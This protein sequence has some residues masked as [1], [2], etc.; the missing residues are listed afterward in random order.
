MD[1]RPIGI[2][3][4]GLGGLTAAGE[5]ARLLPSEHIIYFGDTGR[6]PYGSRSKETIL[7]YAN[8]DVAFLKSFDLKAIVIACGTVSTVAIEQLKMQN[9]LPIVGVVEPAAMMA[10]KV[11]QNGKVGLIG[12]SASV[13]SG[14]YEKVIASVSLDINVTAQACPLLVPLIEAGRVHEG[15][16][17]TETVLSE[18]LEPMKKAQ[19][20]TLVLG[21]THYPLLK[22]MIAKQMGDHVTL[23]DTGEEC[24][25]HVAIL[26]KEQDLL[27]SHTQTEGKRQYFVSDA[28]EG[29]VRTASF[30][31]GEQ[32]EDAVERVDIDTYQF[33]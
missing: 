24:A 4:S 10:A 16:C 29:F 30:F 5:L 25:K 26:L 20:D 11:T 8:Q 33:D 21:C 28:P 13:N 27:T 6:V 7:K 32:I 19:V 9:D 23:I 22:G 15:D 31:L 2:F 18:Y 12:T 1:E 17:V 14:A 3:D